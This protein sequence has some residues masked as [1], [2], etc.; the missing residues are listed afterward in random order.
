L[1]TQLLQGR[2]WLTACVP[3]FGNQIARGSVPDPA[4][5]WYPYSLDDADW[6][7]RQDWRIAWPVT[8]H[9]R[10]IPDGEMRAKELADREEQF[11]C[12]PRSRV[13]DPAPDTPPQQC[14]L[15]ILSVRP[16][17]VQLE[18]FGFDF[19]RD[20]LDEMSFG[21]YPDD[22]RSLLKIRDSVEGIAAL[23]DAASRLS[24]TEEQVR[25]AIEELLNRRP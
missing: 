21:A 15:R 9:V 1:S 7:F 4:R 25:V 11:Q 12:E 3:N 8:Y 10:W 24:A 14:W 16:H 5:L 23:M 20:T 19:R 22:W 17:W 6:G 2:D 18:P 13:P